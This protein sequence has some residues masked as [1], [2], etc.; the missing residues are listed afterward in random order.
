MQQTVTL[1][2][3]PC[4]PP[5]SANPE[6]KPNWQEHDDNDRAVNRLKRLSTVMG[7]IKNQTK[8]KADKRTVPL[9]NPSRATAPPG[10]CRLPLLV[11]RY[12][13]WFMVVILLASL[14]EWHFSVH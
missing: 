1:I 9:Q 6:P 13:C 7:R 3:T 14:A 8:G 10:G 2:L 4:A 5:L 11:E 12:A